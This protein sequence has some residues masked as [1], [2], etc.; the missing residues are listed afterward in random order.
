MN[1]KYIL[2]ALLVVFTGSNAVYALDDCARKTLTIVAWEDVPE[3]WTDCVG[4]IKFSRKSIDEN[5]ANDKYVGEFKNGKMH[6]QGTYTSGGKWKGQVYVGEYKEGKRSGQGTM[7]LKNGG[8]YVGEWKDDKPHGLGKETWENGQVYRGGYKEGKRNGQG[9]MTYADGN[10]YVGEWVDGKKQGQGTE[11][12]ND[13][14]NGYY[15]G[16]RE[17]YV[18]EFKDG[19]INGRGTYTYNNK[20]IYVGDWKNG[21]RSGQGT[22]TYSKDRKYIG[23]WMDDKEH[24]QGT[25]TEKFGNKTVGEWSMGRIWNGVQITPLG[26]YREDRVEYIRGREQPSKRVKTSAAIARDDAAEKERLEK[27]KIF[28]EKLASANVDKN[29]C[30]TLLTHSYNVLA[31]ELQYTAPEVRVVENSAGGRFLN[32]LQNAAAQADVDLLKNLKTSVEKIKVINPIIDSA[33]QNY[34]TLKYSD[35]ST[36]YK[37]Y[38]SKDAKNLHITVACQK[39]TESVEVANP[40]E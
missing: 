23:E 20:N 8:N 19:E 38:L 1:K 15:G 16:K 2:A 26:P 22:L 14:G 24:G 11:T 9:S 29:K 33:T 18:G 40:F 10:E 13:E 31:K 39:F 7:T 36:L 25:L 3:S 30:Y 27:E 21:K 6:G 5:R 4:K 37:E 17:K 28:E 34:L 12:F 32:N 35:F